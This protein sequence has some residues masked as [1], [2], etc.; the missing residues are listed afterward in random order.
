MRAGLSQSPPI[1]PRPRFNGGSCR[2]CGERGAWRMHSRIV[3]AQETLLQREMVAGDRRRRPARG[4]RNRDGRRGLGNVQL[5]TVWQRDRRWPRPGVR[6]DEGTPWE[7]APWPVVYLNRGD[8]LAVLIVIEKQAE[9]TSKTPRSSV[10]EVL[11][12]EMVPIS[13]ALW[14]GLPSRLLKNSAKW[15]RQ[16]NPVVLRCSQH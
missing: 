6:R 10:D 2:P 3:E 8:R 11:C 13:N 15:D 12:N 16:I 14:T 9:N 5:G 4:P 1:R 7:P